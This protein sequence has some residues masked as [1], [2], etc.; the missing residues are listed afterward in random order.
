MTLIQLS[1]PNEARLLH[2]SLHSFYKY[3]SWLPTPLAASE[4]LGVAKTPRF[5]G[6]G[7]ESI[8]S[9]RTCIP[10]PAAWHISPV[11]PL[12]RYSTSCVNNERRI[13]DYQCRRMWSLPQKKQEEEKRKKEYTCMLSWICAYIHLGSQP[14][15]FNARYRVFAKMH[16][17]IRTNPFQFQVLGASFKISCMIVSDSP[18]PHPPRF[19]RQLVH[20]TTQCSNLP[21]FAS[22]NPG[23]RG[24]A[25]FPAQEVWARSYAELLFN[26][27]FFVVASKSLT[28]D[29]SVPFSKYQ[30]IH[31]VRCCR[32]TL[33]NSVESYRLDLPFGDDHSIFAEF[34]LVRFLD[35]EFF[36]FCILCM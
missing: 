10:P 22:N 14:W 32:P 21:S 34:S 20:E 24:E 28:H 36:M 31:R 17:V 6:C 25:D 30:D 4:V 23:G 35:L 27:F 18:P 7:A 16:H 8:Y 19:E 13:K 12:R 26:F 3:S 5:S 2:S 29:A 15:H 11:L 9:R 1:I 33:V